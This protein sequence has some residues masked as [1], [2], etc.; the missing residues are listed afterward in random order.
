[1][2]V[3]SRP[4][5]AA[6]STTDCVRGAGTSTTEIAALVGGDD[7]ECECMLCHLPFG[8]PHPPI[9]WRYTVRFPGPYPAPGEET[10]LLCDP[11]K[12]DWE[13][14]QGVL[15]GHAERIHKV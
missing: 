15:M 3:V 14:D 11:C 5:D 2:R 7:I 8:Q 4:A 10:M 9:E 6:T 12:C 1:M 13:E